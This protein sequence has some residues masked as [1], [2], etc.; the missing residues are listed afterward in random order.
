[1]QTTTVCS[2]EKS[3]FHDLDA[4]RAS[5]LL[6]GVFF[7]IAESYCPGRYSWAI[8]DSH[9]HRLFDMFQNTCHNFRMQLFFV[10][11]GFF[12]HL[13]FQK[14][15]V[16][17][18]AI[19]R[20]TRIL[21]PLL[22]FWPIL[23][24]IINSLWFWGAKVGN[25]LTEAGFPESTHGLAPWKIG[26]GMWGDPGTI[27][28]HFS[29][30]HLWFLYYLVLF[31]VF[32][33]VIWALARLFPLVSGKLSGFC[34]RSFSKLVS[35][36][37]NI[38][39]FSLVFLG[40]MW[41]MKGW[42]VDTP[43]QSLIPLRGPTLL[44]GLCFFLGW[45]LHR[46]YDLIDRFTKSWP[47][48]LALATVII[49][50][51]FWMGDIV[52]Y[53]A[54]GD[55]LPL[56]AWRVI[57]FGL[58]SCSMIMF[59]MGFMG[60]FRKCCSGKSATWRYVADSSYWIYILHI[61]VVAALDIVVAPLDYPAL[62]KYGVECAIAF[63]I[64]FLTYHFLVRSTIIGSLLNGRTYPFVLPRISRQSVTEEAEKQTA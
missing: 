24:T 30:L 20:S 6:L 31:Y 15:G 11:A 48:K 8:V 27:V 51:I 45:F 49:S 52:R 55:K 22:L 36:R 46:N 2:G 13:L 37:F 3:R 9:A 34:D 62:L 19:N 47:I 17:S 18:Y 10:I 58:Y 35:S 1:M 14:R 16:A 59:I 57:Y 60:L 42:T 44:Y 63:P 21:L 64:L 43:N 61:P 32:T 33:I 38:L 26:I 29:T 28:E 39:L 50:T 40:C 25:R 41:Q 7:H 53:F 4:L 12:A 56:Y 54:V 5:A 23:T